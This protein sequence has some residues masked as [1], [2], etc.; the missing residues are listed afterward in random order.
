MIERLA[1]LRSWVGRE[2]AGDLRQRL[3]GGDGGGLP[4]GLA[5]LVA[6][7]PGMSILVYRPSWSMRN[8]REIRR[9]STYS[10]TIWRRSL[11]PV[12]RSPRVRSRP[13]GVGSPRGCSG[14]CPAGAGVLALASRLG[15]GSWLGLAPGRVI[16]GAWIPI[17]AASP[18]GVGGDAP[19]VATVRAVSTAAPATAG[20]SRP[21][22]RPIVGAIDV[23]SASSRARVG[24]PAVRTGGGLGCP[25]PGM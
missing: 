15:V 23:M 25:V 14:R 4:L 24:S 16:A 21:P 18:I 19:A 20:R 7:E 2:R 17:G 22:T 10:P 8:P 6:R 12:G 3:G 13:A 11:I 1:D 9:S 5:A